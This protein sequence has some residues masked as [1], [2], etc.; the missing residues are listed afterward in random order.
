MNIMRIK[1]FI[2]VLLLCISVHAYTQ[3]PD[4]HLGWSESELK[5]EIPDLLE[6]RKEGDVVVYAKGSGGEGFNFYYILKSNVVV[7]EM[8]LLLSK[9][10][11]VKK[12]YDILLESYIGLY[13]SNL[14]TKDKNGAFFRF[15]TFTLELSY[16]VDGE[17][18]TMRTVFQ[19]VANSQ[20]NNS[21]TSPVK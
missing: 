16:I 13:P 7:T 2:A 17:M 1:L 18:N 12:T 14:E 15:S 20:T 4:N 5:K 10:E 9:D 8:N 19:M 21:S 11:L 6:I 3:E